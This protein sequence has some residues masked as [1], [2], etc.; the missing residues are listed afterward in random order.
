MFERLEEGLATKIPQENKGYQLL[1]KLGFKEGGTV[2]KQKEDESMV[3]REPIEIAIK[4]NKHG[5][6]YVD[7]RAAR[8]K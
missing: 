6:E 4:G 7:P 3:L 8:I 5:I 1:L 2:G